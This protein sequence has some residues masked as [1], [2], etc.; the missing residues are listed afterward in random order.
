MKNILYLFLAVTILACSSDDS[1]D[2]NDNSNLTSFEQVVI[3][4]TWQ[5]DSESRFIFEP[6]TVY[7]IPCN[8]YGNYDILSVDSDLL[9]QLTYWHCY[10]QGEE[11]GGYVMQPYTGT[12][13]ITQL[14]ETE[15]LLGSDE[16]VINSFTQNQFTVTNNSEGVYQTWIKID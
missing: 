7:A 10:N 4:N 13:Q 16:I 5:L 14:S 6:N 2:T 1:S 12:F 3:G 8:E 15:Y 11:P 9:A